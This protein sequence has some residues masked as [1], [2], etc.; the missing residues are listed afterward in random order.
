M[1]MVFDQ[2]SLWNCERIFDVVEES[3]N[4]LHAFLETI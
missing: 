4:V 2:V 1:E 3:R